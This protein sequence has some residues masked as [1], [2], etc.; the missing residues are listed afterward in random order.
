MFKMALGPDMAVLAESVKFKNR[1]KTVM[2]S[3]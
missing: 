3:E 1:K 2:G